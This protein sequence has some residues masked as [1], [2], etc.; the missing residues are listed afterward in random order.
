MCVEV[1]R[2]VLEKWEKVG[3]GRILG[4]WFLIGKFLFFVFFVDDR[5]GG[6]LRYIWSEMSCYVLF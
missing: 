6:N 1:Y 5:E 2:W 3:K 4:F